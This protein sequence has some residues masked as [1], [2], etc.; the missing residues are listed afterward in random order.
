VDRAGAESLKGVVKWFNDAKGY[1]FIEHT[2]GKD[3]FV[4][5]S[6]IISEGFKSLKDGEPV[7]YEMVQG[8]KGLHA[9]RVVRM[10]KDE[11]PTEGQSAPS[12]ASEQASATLES[13]GG[14]EGAQ[15]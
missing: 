11:S 10:A 8:E 15:H 13:K 3:V 6:S 12:G 14:S 7:E 1:G 5:Y 2:S 4:H 9:V